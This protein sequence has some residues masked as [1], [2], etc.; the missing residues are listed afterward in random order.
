MLGE[1]DSGLADRPVTELVERAR[2]DLVHV[3]EETAPQVAGKQRVEAE[4]EH[5]EPLT[6]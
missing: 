2:Y 3:S 5:P 1:I 6:G 4:D